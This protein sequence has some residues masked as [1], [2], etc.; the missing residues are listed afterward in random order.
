V[1]I[2]GVKQNDIMKITRDTLARHL[3]EYQLE[4]VGKTMLDT[5]NDIDWRTNITLTQEQF[6]EFEKY[7]KKLIRKVYKCNKSKG[8][9][10]FNWFFPAFG[11]RIKN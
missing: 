1:E 10:Y 9:H 3:L 4:M 5:F 6:N 7:S 8:D 11:L 2:V